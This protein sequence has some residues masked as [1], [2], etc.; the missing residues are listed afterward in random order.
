MGDEEGAGTESGRGG[1]R[2]VG[3]DR[4]SVRM[5]GRN[6]RELDIE[7]KRERERS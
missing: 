4:A 2:G 3:K 1:D 7:W 6:W 5:W